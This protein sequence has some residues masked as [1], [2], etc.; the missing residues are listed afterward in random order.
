MTF[1]EFKKLPIV[2]ANT[3]TVYEQLKNLV[4][5]AAY[6]REKGIESRLFAESFFD[7]VKNTKGLIKVLKKL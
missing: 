6:R 2:E 1:P 3:E 5:D 4:K 7:P